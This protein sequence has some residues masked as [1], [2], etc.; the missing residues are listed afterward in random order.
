MSDFKDHFSAQSPDYGKYRPQYPEALFEHL[1]SLSPAHAIAWDSATGTGQAALGLTPFYDRVI[2]TDASSN[3][4]EHAAR[5]PKIDYRVCP[6]EDSGI[7]EASVDLVVVAQALHWFDL[8]GFFDEC[9]RVL[10]DQG[11][12]AIWSYG[13]HRISP[14]IDSIIDHFYDEMVGI[15][16][17]PERKMVEAGY[18]TIELPFREIT[19]PAFHMQ[20]YWTLHRLYGY[21]NT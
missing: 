6:S 11:V 15:Y 17:P 5:H 7:A 14:E 2:A 1:A 12:I 4:I 13:L 19:P 8:D 3:Q 9:L 16:W 20:A 18:R 10:K 21:L